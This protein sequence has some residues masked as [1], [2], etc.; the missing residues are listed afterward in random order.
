MILTSLFSFTLHSI[1]RH[2]HD[3]FQVVAQSYRYSKAF[4]NKLFF[5]MVDFDEGAEVFQY[6]S[7]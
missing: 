4:S 5:A 6:V 3:E 1:F 2:A 7:D